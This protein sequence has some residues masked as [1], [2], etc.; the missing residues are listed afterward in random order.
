MCLVCVVAQQ[1]LLLALRALPA[2]GGPRFVDLAALC[3]AVAS[4]AAQGLREVWRDASAMLQRA[5]RC[6]IFSPAGELFSRAGGQE[7]WVA[8]EL[9]ARVAHR[10]RSHRL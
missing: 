4:R 1:E 7:V 8:P 3:A 10:P 6:M 9:G 5:A 2:L